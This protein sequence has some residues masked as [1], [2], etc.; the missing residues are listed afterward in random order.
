M[1]R[2]S[3]RDDATKR[4]PRKRMQDR[5]GPGN[6]VFHPAR[7]FSRRSVG[8]LAAAFGRGYRHEHRLPTILRT[9]RSAPLPEARYAPPIASA[10]PAT[11]DTEQPAPTA[12]HDGR[13]RIV[14]DDHISHFCLVRDARAVAEC[15]KFRWFS[16]HDLAAGLLT[17]TRRHRSS[18]L[19]PIQHPPRYQDTAPTE[20]NW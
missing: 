16:G 19:H 2:R 20:T 15:P 10:M 7:G 9:A 18:A 3:G 13:V 17:G 1:F 11:I 4:P 5:K 14:Q 12:L 6:G 8:S